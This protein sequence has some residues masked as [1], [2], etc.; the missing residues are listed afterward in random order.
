MVA[1]SSFVDERGFLIYSLLL[2]I[3]GS[4]TE[5]RRLKPQV[6]FLVY[7][8][9]VGLALECTFVII[10]VTKSVD[11]GDEFSYVEDSVVRTSEGLV[12]CHP[13]L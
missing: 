12:L 7:S 3:W 10:Y 8:E 2:P 13:V 1:D 5:S 11:L 9:G 4:F 6:I